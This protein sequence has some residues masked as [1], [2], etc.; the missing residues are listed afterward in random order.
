MELISERMLFCLLV[1]KQ[2]IQQGGKFQGTRNGNQF[3]NGMELEEFLRRVIQTFEGVNLPPSLSAPATLPIYHI[4][5][6]RIQAKLLTF[7]DLPLYSI[8]LLKF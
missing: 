3:G 7:R 1:S 5:G 8:K 2:S 6:I 4:D